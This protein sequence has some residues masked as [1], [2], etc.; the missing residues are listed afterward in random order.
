MV[1]GLGFGVQ[2]RGHLELRLFAAEILWWG[3]CQIFQLASLPLGV[4][5]AEHTHG[6]LNSR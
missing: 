6:L 2:L 5:A 4:A 3:S 1:Q